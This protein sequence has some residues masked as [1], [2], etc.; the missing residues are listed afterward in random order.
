MP[1]Q[2]TRA[3]SDR[4]T[5]RADAVAIRVFVKTHAVACAAGALRTPALLLRSGV[6]NVGR[7]MQLYPAAAAVGFFDRSCATGAMPDAGVPTLKEVLGTDASQ[8]QPGAAAA[9]A[10][11]EADA[12]SSTDAPSQPAAKGSR[13][14]KCTAADTRLC[15]ARLPPHQL[16]ALLPFDSGAALQRDVLA[17][18]R[19]VC[20]LAVECGGVAGAGAAGRLKLGREVR[21]CAC[22]VCAQNESFTYYALDQ[23]NSVRSSNDHLLADSSES[24]DALSRH[25]T[26]SRLHVPGMC[27][28]RT[29]H[30]ISTHVLVPIGRTGGHL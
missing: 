1:V 10:D 6:R 11:E 26:E 7:H 2:S 16:A 3:D 29:R 21:L 27:S 4:Q 22:R 12:A 19:S 13:T 15:H 28:C 5:T 23:T 9:A 14:H 30:G 17:M 24:H 18:T 20:L 25:E 8:E